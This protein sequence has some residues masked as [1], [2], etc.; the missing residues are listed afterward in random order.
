MGSDNIALMAQIANAMHSVARL[1]IR[2]RNGFTI[3]MYLINQ[4]DRTISLAYFSYLFKHIL[5]YNCWSFFFSSVH[6]VTLSPP[7]FFMLYA[8]QSFSGLPPRCFIFT[9]AAWYNL[10]FFF[11]F[12]VLL[13]FSRRIY[14]CPGLYRFT[15]KGRELFFARFL[16]S[17]SLFSR[18]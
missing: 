16:P 12:Y 11:T 9:F 13:E 4:T 3:A 6:I 14:S 8:T 2:G 15:V 5:N 1:P 7:S 17:F 18:D 10:L